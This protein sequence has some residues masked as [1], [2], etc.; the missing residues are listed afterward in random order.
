[1]DETTSDIKFTFAWQLIEFDSFSLGFEYVHVAELSATLWF[2]LFLSIATNFYEKPRQKQQ[3]NI[4]NF[5]LPWTNKEK[6]YA[7]EKPK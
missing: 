4:K 1:M 5:C 3:E 7:K 6:K 2:T